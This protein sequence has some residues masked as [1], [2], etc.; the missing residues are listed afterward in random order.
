MEASH[1]P[2]ASTS[3]LAPPAPPPFA[4][5]G[6]PAWIFSDNPEPEEQAA[7]STMP[8][9]APVAFGSNT[10][11]AG[12]GRPRIDLEGD[13]SEASYGPTVRRRNIRFVPGNGAGELVTTDNVKGKAKEGTV[14]GG[15][16]RGKGDQVKSLYESIVSRSQTPTSAA[17][18]PPPP[19]APRTPPAPQPPPDI[20]LTADSESDSDDDMIILDPLTG[21]PVLPLKKKARPLPLHELINHPEA[22]P[23]VP[24]IPYAFKQSHFGYQ[25]LVKH[26]WKEGEGLGLS[27]EGLKI[28]LKS[29]DKFDKGGLGADAK[30]GDGMS[31]KEWLEKKRKE[32]KRQ[33]E[34]MGK[35]GRGMAR[36]V[37]REQRER[38]AM[39]R[40]F[41]E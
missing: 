17:A 11:R 36:V 21:D 10:R 9:L 7:A 2:V 3:R 15:F 22:A 30:R 31:K 23:I 12:L 1:Q 37:K 38:K 16:V 25:M 34:L 40:Y 29:S 39:L 33:R 4:G 35:G 5:F 14:V 28:P 8:H 24:P 13:E 27:Q 19:A 6:P 41:N 26:G 32:E 20:D 18:T